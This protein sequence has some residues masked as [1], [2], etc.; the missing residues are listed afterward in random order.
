GSASAVKTVQVPDEFVGKIHHTAE[1]PQAAAVPVAQAPVIQVTD[2]SDPATVKGIK[3]TKS[4]VA[5]TIPGKTR[6]NTKDSQVREPVARPVIMEPVVATIKSSPTLVTQ[7]NIKTSDPS[8]IHLTQQRFN[9]SD[10]SVI[11]K[12]GSDILPEGILSAPFLN[13]GPGIPTTYAGINGA[14]EVIVYEDGTTVEVDSSNNL[15][16]DLTAF[17]T[18]G[19]SINRGPI[20]SQVRPSILPVR[21]NY[22]PFG[23]IN[24]PLRSTT[25]TGGGS[26]NKNIT[27]NQAIPNIPGAVSQTLPQP[28][29]DADIIQ[30]NRQLQKQS[31]EELKR[32]LSG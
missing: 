20:G 15:G 31:E 26:T 11:A 10:V 32:T 22:A 28:V 3:T 5:A 12:G 6:F 19:S 21:T 25:V 29:I 1:L 30:L 8:R 14:K 7:K 13:K 4:V 18:Q 16:P 2:A 9:P 27:P 23:R 24:A 17:R